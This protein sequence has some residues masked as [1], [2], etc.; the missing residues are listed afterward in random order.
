MGFSCCTQRNRGRSYKSTKWV[1]KGPLLKAPNDKIIHN[2]VENNAFNGERFAEFINELIEKCK[3]LNH[4]K[5][6][7][8]MD[9]VRMHKAEESIKDHCA[10]NN[11]D[12]LFLPVYSPELNPIEK[13]FSILRT[14][15]HD[16]FLE[17]D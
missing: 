2:K 1:Q 10:K 17:T 6:C 14:T 7:F 13:V 15:Y 4:D 16:Q 11:I 9:N 12:I 5:I 8:I 3:Q